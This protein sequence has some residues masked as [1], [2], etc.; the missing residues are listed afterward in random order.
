MTPTEAVTLVR[1]VEAGCPSMRMAEQTPDVWFDAGLRDIDFE[2]AKEAAVQLLRRERYVGLNDIIA[3]SGKIDRAR[4]GAVRRAE[5]LAED[6]AVMPIWAS[7]QPEDGDTPA[8]F[9][10]RKKNAE[11]WVALAAQLKAVRAEDGRAPDERRAEAQ[12]ELDAV[13]SRADEAG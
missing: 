7:A 5:L 10:Q 6:P 12:A 2:L 11:R 13:R 4:R 8:T 1:Y 3:E 9:E